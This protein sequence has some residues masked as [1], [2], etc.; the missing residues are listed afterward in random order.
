MERKYRNSPIVEAVCEFTFL[1]NSQWDMTIP[2]LFYDQVKSVFP[3]KESRLLVSKK[4]P[5]KSKEMT[6]EETQITNLVAFLAPDSKTYIHIGE[7]HLSI[8]RSKPYQSW[9]DFKP[10]I[11]TNLSIL[12]SILPDLTI[13]R[14]GLLYVNHIE[15]PYT[16][17]NMEDYFG[18]RPYLSSELPNVIQS[19]N[20]TCVFDFPVSDR[21]RVNMSSALPVITDNRAVLFQIDYGLNQPGSI[22]PNRAMDWVETAH[23]RVQN[24][25]EGCITEHTRE[26]F[27]EV[28]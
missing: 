5:V 12:T 3:K 27:D 8:H 6:T 9:S 23:V 28:K 13:N 17:V 14:I 26:L 21:C 19:F 20:V 15:I 7:N 11:S 10:L 22:L 24:I 1:A 25:F 4:N 18:F 2:G 16:S